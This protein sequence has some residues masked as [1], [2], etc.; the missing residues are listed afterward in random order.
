MKSPFFLIISKSA[1]KIHLLFLQLTYIVFI[2]FGM[3]TSPTMPLI[4]KKKGIPHHY[5]NKQ[6]K[7]SYRDIKDSLFFHSDIFLATLEKVKLNIKKLLTSIFDWVYAECRNFV[8]L[9]TAFSI[10]S[11]CDFF[12]KHCNYYAGK[13]LRV[14]SGGSSVSGLQTSQ[15]QICSGA[16]NFVNLTNR[17]H[18]D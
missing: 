3:Q 12:S 10:A 11:Q 16:N 5:K 1:N 14:I 18:Y 9:L 6:I 13:L 17:G 7:Y 4:F 15:L 8:V 2:H